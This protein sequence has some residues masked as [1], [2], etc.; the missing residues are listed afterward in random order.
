MYVAISAAKHGVVRVLNQH[1]AEV[2]KMV[3]QTIE[4]RVPWAS[5]QRSSQKL[6]IPSSA[7]IRL[8]QRMYELLSEFRMLEPESRLS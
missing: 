8:M 6:C 1:P 7:E 2:K 5:G 4:M 3:T